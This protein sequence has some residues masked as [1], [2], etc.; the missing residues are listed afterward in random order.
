MLKGF[1]NTS[2]AIETGLGDDI[3]HA[4]MYRGDE[5]RHE[6]ADERIEFVHIDSENRCG[7]H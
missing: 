5:I 7:A 4:S 6:L 3:D 1:R 2:E